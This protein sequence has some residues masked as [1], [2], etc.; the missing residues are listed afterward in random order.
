MYALRVDL[1]EA[2]DLG[3]AIGSNPPKNVLFELFWGSHQV[4]SHYVQTLFVNVVFYRL[5]ARLHIRGTELSGTSLLTK[6]FQSILYLFCLIVLFCLTFCR[7][8]PRSIPDIFINIYSLPATGEQTRIG[9]L[10][11]KVFV[12]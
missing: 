10:Q 5:Y 2:T 6:F 4:F 7:F 11:L 12:R 8:H 3:K 1:Y 9:F